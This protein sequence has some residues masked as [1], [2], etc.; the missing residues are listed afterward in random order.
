MRVLHVIS[1]M[2]QGG[3]ATYLE[4]LLEGL[5]NAGVETLLVFGHV[6]K[7][8]VEAE[9]KT[10]LSRVK[11]PQL[12][13]QLSLIGDLKSARE[14]RKVIENFSPN[15][16]HSH[17]FKGGLISRAFNRNGTM[18]VH[19]FH[20]HHLYDPEFGII[21]RAVMNRVE[22]FLAKSTD[23][24]IT[25]GVRVGLE[26]QKAEAIRGAFTSIPPGVNK[27]LLIESR[28]AREILGVPENSNCVVGW[29]GRFV[30]VKRPEFLTK[31][32]ELNPNITFVAAGNG[33]LFDRMHSSKPPNLILPG[34]I[35]SGL[36]LSASDI[37]VSTSI[38]EGMPL[39]LIEA[40]RCG[41]ATISP[42]VGSVSEIVKH[43]ETGF[44]TST[45]LSDMNR[46]INRL[47]FNTE[48]RLRLSG[49]ALVNAE[50][51]FSVESMVE[52]HLSVYDRAL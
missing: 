35:N 50:R 47:V 20:G 38:S 18:R 22:S 17:A 25:V 8:E 32:A 21:E 40:Q 9:F 45:D 19:T 41:I 2:N 52:R 29:M 6:T 34:W 48:E 14:L 46:Y 30:D 4:N 28:K 37:F 3:T 33:P 44:I 49:N 36:V 42:D 43:E 10:S 1:R 31:L 23:V 27:P 12:S 51:N 24:T 11:I 26:L 13:R 39:A 15:V 7:N 16:I 5:T